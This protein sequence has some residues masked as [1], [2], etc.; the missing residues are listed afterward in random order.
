MDVESQ[1]TIDEAIDRAKAS[2]DS[3]A[4]AAI[5]SLQNAGTV[6]IDRLTSEAGNILHGLE[7]SL[8]DTESKAVEDLHGLLD[9]LNGARLMFIEG[10][11]E[12][13]V[14]EKK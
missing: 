1:Q 14:P 3:S 13:Q 8:T 2:I 12:L 4:A 10:G 6:L 5:D 11:F 7:V 9:R